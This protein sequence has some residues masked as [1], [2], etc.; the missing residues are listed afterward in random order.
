MTVILHPQFCGTHLVT[1]DLKQEAFAISWRNDTYWTLVYV[2][3]YY[4]AV[5]TSSNNFFR[6]NY[7]EVGMNPREVR[8]QA[9]IE[10][11]KQENHTFMA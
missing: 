11:K 1:K 8:K 9:R 10:K 5:S 3:L 4:T 7:L 2:Y 6:E